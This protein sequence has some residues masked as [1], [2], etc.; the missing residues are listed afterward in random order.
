MNNKI[1]ARLVAAVM[2][3]A[4]LGTVSFAATI[5]SVKVDATTDT[6]LN[7]ANDTD[8][9]YAGNAGV[10]TLMAF[11]ADTAD[12][13]PAAADIIAL[14][15]NDDA[16]APA[17]IKIDADKLVAKDYVIVRFGG[18]G[19]VADRVICLD[20]TTVTPEDTITVDGAEFTDVAYFTA[21]IDAEGTV[22]NYGFKIAN[23]NGATGDFNYIMSDDVEEIEGTGFSYGFL[24][25]GVEGA[26]WDATAFYTAE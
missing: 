21:S 9:A 13:E 3:I 14:V 5:S 22:K 1:L 15:Q 11:A 4:M 6:V 25:V 8:A 2:A 24:V 10:K 23:K 20:G 12:A 18:N 17:S 7:V 19:S 16:T 26:D